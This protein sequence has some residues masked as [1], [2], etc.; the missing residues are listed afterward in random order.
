[1]KLHIALLLSLL[2]LPVASFS[3]NWELV[4]SDEFNVDGKPDA[5]KWSFDVEGNEWDWGNNEL[6]NYTPADSGNAWIE[7]G[8]LIIE[9][10]KEKYTAPEDNQ[11]RDY[12]SARLITKN[13][14]DWKYGRFEIKAKLPSGKGT[15]PAIW[16]MNSEADNWPHTGELDIMEAIG[17]E[18]GTIYSTVWCTE[19]ENINGAGSYTTIDDPFNTFHIYSMEWNEDSIHFYT[20]SILVTKWSKESGEIAHWP[21]TQKFHILLNVAVGGD[22]EGSVADST[23]EKPVRMYVD[24]VRVYQEATP[25]KNNIKTIKSSSNLNIKKNS[26]TIMNDLSEAKPANLK[27]YSL[28][29]KIIDNIDINNWKGCYRFT[30]PLSSGFYIACFSRNNMINTWNFIID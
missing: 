6:Q 28:S 2:F 1:M 5:S 8:N 21:F 13:K 7:D 10:R 20:D 18:P 27:I 3:Q 16:M 24:Y 14:G 23:F 15:W 26:F 19:T 4:W 17:S 12:T 25:I 9:A 11:E 22:W 30:N 29:G